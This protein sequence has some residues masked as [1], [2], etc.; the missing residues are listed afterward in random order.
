MQTTTA[1]AAT[2]AAHLTLVNCEN[3]ARNNRSNNHSAAHRPSFIKPLILL[4]VAVIAI[5]ALLAAG[6]A[7]MIR[8]TGALSQS[9]AMQNNAPIWA[10]LIQG[11]APASLPQHSA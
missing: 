11:E 6:R 2:A 7:T 9:S 5:L 8:A 4:A 1:P 10:G 3:D